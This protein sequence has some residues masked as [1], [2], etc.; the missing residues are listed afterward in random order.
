[1][2][3]NFSMMMLA[4][5][6]AAGTSIAVT[7]ILW[8]QMVLVTMITIIAL[9]PMLRNKLDLKNGILLVAL[10]IIGV[11]IQFNLPQ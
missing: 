7:N 5:K 11:S 4:R 6:G 10:Y 3:D 9:I 1:M 2:V 8:Y